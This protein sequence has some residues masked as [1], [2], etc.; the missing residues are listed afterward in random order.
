EGRR[1]LVW[2]GAICAVA[3]GGLQ[4]FSARFEFLL[5]ALACLA[6]TAAHS[7]RLDQESVQDNGH[8]APHAKDPSE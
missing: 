5:A 4:V 8:P 6:S 7:R 3:Y 2:V 1:D